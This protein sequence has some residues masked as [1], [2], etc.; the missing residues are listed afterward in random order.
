MTRKFLSGWLL[1]LLLLLLLV[2]CE[3]AGTPV[4]TATPQAG[5]P[6]AATTSTPA[7]TPVPA[8]TPAGGYPAPA[9][10]QTPY[11]TP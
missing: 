9:A 4:P 3:S 1:T 8:A 6:P 7:R 10:D 11:P 2:A 5:T